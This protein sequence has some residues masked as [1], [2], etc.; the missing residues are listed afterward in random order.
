MKRHFKIAMIGYD[1][2]AEA[3]IILYGGHKITDGCYILDTD[4]TE[5]H[6]K[7]DLSQTAEMVE[8]TQIT[9]AQFEV[10]SRERLGFYAP[11]PY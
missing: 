2:S 11:N 4:E 1:R 6:I 8:M 9:P 3:R 5:A 10:V 7:S